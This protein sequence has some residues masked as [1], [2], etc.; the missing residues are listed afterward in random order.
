MKTLNFFSMFLIAAMLIASCKKED[1]GTPQQITKNYTYSQNIRGS[2]GVKGELILSELK[3]ADIIG[4][5]PAENFKN[6]EMQLANCHLEISG[7][8]Q[9]ESPEGEAVILDDFT[10]KA[11]TRQGVNIGDCSTDPQGPNEFA[12]DDPQSTNEIIS[13]I[14]NIFT[15]ITS[16][17]KSST[18]TVSFTPNV[19]ITSS[20]NVQLKISIGGTYHYVVFE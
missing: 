1:E 4:A 6:A 9:I 12:A 20:D 15:D 8:S 19:D 14:Q 16:G 18:I 3:L 11:G 2:L 17:S 13:I 7:L 5:E 10:I